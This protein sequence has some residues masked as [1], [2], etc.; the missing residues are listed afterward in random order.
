MM[1]LS[2]RLRRSFVRMMTIFAGGLF[3]HVVFV[4]SSKPAAFTENP[5]SNNYLAV[6]PGRGYNY[7]KEKIIQ[8]F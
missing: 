1:F 6:T 2:R 4:F 3:E 7:F 5:T 8:R